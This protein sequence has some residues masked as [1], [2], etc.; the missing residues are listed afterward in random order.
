MMIIW[1][2]KWS[3]IL[4]LFFVVVLTCGLVWL[5]ISSAPNT[6]SP[7][8]SALNE[9]RK[10]LSVVATKTVGPLPNDLPG[11]LRV[12]DDCWT[13]LQQ[14]MNKNANQY[15]LTVTSEYDS[16]G[17][18]RIEV[19]LNIDFPDGNRAEMY[20]SQGGLSGCRKK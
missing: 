7:R 6:L 9:T 8:E 5:Y 17:Y 2:L 11:Y 14:S 1:R 20:Y 19:Y 10:L 3:W 12:N 16:P 4:I 15:K 13:F 18:Q